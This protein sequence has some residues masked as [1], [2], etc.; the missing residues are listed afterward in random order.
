MPYIAVS[1]TGRHVRRNDNTYL[2]CY[3][4][5]EGQTIYAVFDPKAGPVVFDDVVVRVNDPLRSAN[6]TTVIA[7]KDV[8]GVILPGPTD[9]WQNSSEHAITA[10]IACVD[11]EG[12][13]RLYILT[14]ARW[15]KP[16]GTRDYGYY[17][18][19]TCVAKHQDDVPLIGGHRAA[20]FTNIYIDGISYAIVY[21]FFAPLGQRYAYVF[22]VDIFSRAALYITFGDGKCDGTTFAGLTLDEPDFYSIR[23]YG[24]SELTSMIYLQSPQSV[25]G[26]Y[27]YEVFCISLEIDSGTC[28]ATVRKLTNTLGEVTITYTRTY[29]NLLIDDPSPLAYYASNMLLM[30]LGQCVMGLVYVGGE[31]MPRIYKIRQTRRALMS[32]TPYKSGILAK[33]G[34]IVIPTVEI[35]TTYYLRAANGN[36]HI[37]T[38][39]YIADRLMRMYSRTEQVHSVELLPQHLIPLPSGNRQT[40]T[41]LVLFGEAVFSFAWAGYSR[42]RYKFVIQHS[43]LN[44][45][46]TYFGLINGD[47]RNLIGKYV[48]FGEWM[49]IMYTPDTLF[50]PE[51]TLPVHTDIKPDKRP[52]YIFAPSRFA[53]AG[54]REEPRPLLTPRPGCRMRLISNV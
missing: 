14:T 7:I 25:D 12:N 40:A 16:D 39:N 46:E 44:D 50:A 53:H 2:D 15:A 30:H 34:E 4:S 24:T 3:E 17:E 8:R 19:Q 27:P 22:P 43:I 11:A 38:E 51:C 49:L 23:T 1:T 10:A 31:Y 33:R 9:F 47:I 18:A 45:S 52:A 26:K 28:N 32:F 5:R 20:R 21:D 41:S 29:R 37:V 6:G 35:N 54:S 13:L 42:H 36:E 48:Q